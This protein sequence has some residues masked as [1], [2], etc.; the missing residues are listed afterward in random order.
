MPLRGNVMFS[1]R[2]GPTLSTNVAPSPMKASG[3]LSELTV[4]ILMISKWQEAL[5]K[6]LEP[7]LS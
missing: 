7:L 6:L 1:Y 5:N 2:G 4:P 3:L